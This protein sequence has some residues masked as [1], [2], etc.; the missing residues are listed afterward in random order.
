[1]ADPPFVDQPRD[2]GGTAL[3]GTHVPWTL[4]SY[5][6]LADGERGALIDPHGA[7]VWMCAPRWHDAAVFSALIGGSG[8]F[9]VRPDDPWQVWGGRYE[10][11]SLIRVSRWTLTGSQTEC[12]EALALPGDADRAVLLR[13]VRA[14][15]GAA[16]V[17]V[18]LA[19][20]ADFGTRPMTDL[21][22]RDGVWHARSGSLHVRLHGLAHAAVGPDGALAAP[23]AVPA[24]GGHDLVLE[25]S[26]GPRDDPLDPARLWERTERAW[27][28]AVPECR[29]L[30]AAADVRQAYA[31]LTGLTSRSGGMVAAATT[32]LP[33]RA[34]TGRDYDYRYA[35]LRDQAYA[36]TAVARHGP[37]RL[38]DDAVRFTARRLHEDGPHLRPAYRVDGG[39]LPR[40]RT[41]PLPGYP[42]GGNRI[43]NRAGAQFQLD[44]FGEA[45]SLFAAAARLD[46]LDDDARRA[47][48]IAARAVEETWR[49][50]DAGLWE[51]EPAWWTHSRLS[52]VAGLRAAAEALPGPSA[53][54]WEELADAVLRETE[55][56][57]KH[58]TGRWQR[59]PQDARLDAA[60]LR[61]L[62][63][64]RRLADGPA[65]TATREAVERDLTSEGYVYR[66]QHGDHPL[67]RAEG[68]F[69]LC[70]HFMTAACLAEGRTAAAGR[71]FERTRG[72]CG[73]PGLY[74]EE[75]DVV[76]RQLRGNLPQAFVHALLLENA[77]RLAAAP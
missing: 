30:P 28:Q 21:R 68:A 5:A 49:R 61:P 39:P 75:Y 27:A 15:R 14:V 43:G 57:C 46:R 17:Q 22:L 58:P 52:A 31:V 20:R 72:A 65:L 77:V 34:A 47:V 7:V 18:R 42:G 45:L 59:S 67:G 25:I 53:R 3:R 40:E 44:V 29:E 10:D 48:D 70:G 50:P 16:R 36:G 35:W 71:W 33:E 8:D 32:S 19:V 54:R 51:I 23:V 64:D 2:A 66:F 12:R 60:L 69:L 74:A 13:R 63:M 56:T 76:Q 1:M 26:A 62:S 9:T 4:R 6:L 73:S 41:L 38:V 37:H 24:G 55:R 11:G